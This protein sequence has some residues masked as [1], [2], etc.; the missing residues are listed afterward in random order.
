MLFGIVVI[1]ELITVVLVVLILLV[2]DKALVRAKETSIVEFVNK[3]STVACT[4]V[5]TKEERFG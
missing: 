3:F 2:I 1:K 5:F 4:A